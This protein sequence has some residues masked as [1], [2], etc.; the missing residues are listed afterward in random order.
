MTTAI[1]LHRVADYD[2]W[3]PVYDALNDT[4]DAAG[5]TD[6][7][8]L[9]SQDDAQF[10]IIRHEFA[11]RDAADAFFGG[12]ELKQAMTDAGVD[13]STLQIHIADPT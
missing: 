4:R 1:V 3:R 11:T 2:A 8:V 7:E 12:A 5:V 10:V 6:Q 13:T 9:R